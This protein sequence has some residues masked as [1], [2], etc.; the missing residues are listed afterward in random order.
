MQHT[1]TLNITNTKQ[2]PDGHQKRT[3][4]N[5]ITATQPKNQD[6]RHTHTRLVEQNQRN[7]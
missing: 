1:S 6:F 2:N 3:Q 7:I 5:A 4:Q